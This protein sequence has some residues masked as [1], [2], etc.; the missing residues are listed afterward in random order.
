METTKKIKELMKENNHSK[1]DLA[2]LLGM[3]KLNLVNKLGNKT[4]WKNKDLQKLAKI[5]NK[6]IEYFY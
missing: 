3:T 6:D 1:V 5:Y 4:I 2:R